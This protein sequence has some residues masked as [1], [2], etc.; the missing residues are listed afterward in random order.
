VVVVVCFYLVMALAALLAV[1]V[2]ALIDRVVAWAGSA[3]PP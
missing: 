1:P 3:S 2:N